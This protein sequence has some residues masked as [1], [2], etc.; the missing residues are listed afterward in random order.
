[1]VN[2]PIIRFFE[3]DTAEVANP[4][5]RRNIPG[6]FGFKQIIAS[7][8]QTADPKLPASTSGTLLFDGT[9]FNL[10]GGAISHQASKVA[11]VTVNLGSSGVAISEMKLFLRDD[12][13]LR[14]SMDQGL[15][16]A[17]IQMEAS[18]TWFPGITLPS[19]AVAQVPT[20][21]PDSPNLKRQDGTLA[22]L[23]EDDQNSSQY[24]YM[25][26]VIPLGHPL[27]EYGVCGSGAIRFGL[28]FSYFPI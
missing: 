17:I 19:G 18:G 26:V 9:R 11:A 20:S 7:G 27:G 4:S 21:V 25:N 22:L 13:G 5:G 23:G 3:W 15:D 2:I 16:P 28:M 1:M 8:C 24:A 6:G 10:T 12:S 14:A